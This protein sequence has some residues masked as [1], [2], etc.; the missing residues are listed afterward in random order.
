MT[1]DPG[2]GQDQALAS[3]LE[4]II[5]QRNTKSRAQAMGAEYQLVSLFLISIEYGS[6]STIGGVFIKLGSCQIH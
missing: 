3:A 6:Y 1:Q 2:Q 4:P 5:P